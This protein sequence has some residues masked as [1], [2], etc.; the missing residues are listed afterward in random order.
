ML[1]EGASVFE[2]LTTQATRDTVDSE[3]V[4]ICQDK[5][6]FGRQSKPLGQ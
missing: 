4:R 1:K 2:K 5:I 3:E 6:S